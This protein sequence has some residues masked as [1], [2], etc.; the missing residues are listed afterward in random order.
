MQ[1][2]PELRRRLPSDECGVVKSP[3]VGFL[4]RVQRLCKEDLCAMVPQQCEGR[5]GS[6]TGS[7]SS[8]SSM[9]FRSQFV[10]KRSSTP[11]TDATQVR[12]FFFTSVS[13][14]ILISV[15]NEMKKVGR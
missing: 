14:L 5:S 1:P 9:T 6:P 15:G 7:T 8:S 3:C 13:A 2:A 10:D 11:Y 12:T 4:V